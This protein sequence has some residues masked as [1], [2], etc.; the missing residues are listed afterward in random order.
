[1]SKVLAIAK[2][3]YLT[4]VKSKAFLIGIILMPILMG[5]ALIGQKLLEDKV[6]LDDRK[7]AVVDYSGELYPALEAAVQ[8]RNA[9]VFEGEGDELEQTGP[10][11]V[12]ERV[13]PATAGEERIDLELADRVRD[14]ELF[15]FL[16]IGAN[17]L[18]EAGEDRSIRY[19]TDT[20]TF[21]Q[22]PNWA[23]EVLNAHVI[24]QRFDRAGYDQAAIATLN[25]QTPFERLGL[26]TVAKDTGEVIEAE[27][28]NDV[29]NQAV[30][31]FGMILLFMLIMMAAPPALNNVLE[32]KMQKISEVLVSAVTPFQLIL[33][34][35][36][37][38]VAIAVT[39]SGLYL[40]GVAFVLDYFG[41]SDMVEPRLY[42]WFFL[43]LILAVFIFGAIFSAIGAACSEIRDAQSLMTPA[44]LLVMLPMFLFG[45]VVN[46]PESG[47]A[48]AASLFPP[49]TPFLMFLR[50]GIPPGAPAWEIA[51]G[52][53]L[54]TLFTLAAVWA[55][56]KVFRIGLL[57]QGQAPTLMKLL[58]WIVKG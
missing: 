51:V 11:F 25:R 41:Y 52:V 36:V 22:L 35:L 33:G 56:A 42:A 3:E 9:S 48:R 12:L 57:S 44:M 1:M 31:A 6:D 39:L 18:D 26:A 5:G 53:V 4:A 17:V 29:K 46:A 55:A 45:P 7:L 21:D 40:G 47:L 19:H 14:D 10:K 28:E 50:I 49:A 13:E 58:G 54:C 34:K 8:A 20:P 16:M 24:S 15:A 27:K 30:P 38:T 32:E 43:F 37:G 2:A 23:R